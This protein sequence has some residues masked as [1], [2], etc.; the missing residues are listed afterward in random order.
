MNTPKHNKQ[1][2]IPPRV[3]VLLF[4]PFCSTLR[5]CVSE[6]LAVTDRHN[7]QHL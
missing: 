4:P 7:T 1:R 5:L 3:P 2:K 6:D